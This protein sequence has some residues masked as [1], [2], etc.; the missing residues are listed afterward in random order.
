MANEPR[1]CI[2]EELLNVA[3]LPIVG[4]DPV[5]GHRNRIAKVRI[6]FP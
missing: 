3:N 2:Y 1:A 6:L 4:L 5:T